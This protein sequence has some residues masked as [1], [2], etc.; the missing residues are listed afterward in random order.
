MYLQAVDLATPALAALDAQRYSEARVLLERAAAANPNDGRLHASLALAYFKLNL[1]QFA[2]NAARRAEALQQNSPPT[3]HALALFYAQ[4]GN[5]KRAAELESLYALSPLADPSAPARAAFLNAE[6][7]NFPQALRFARIALERTPTS[8]LFALAANAAEASNQLAEAIELHKQ[9]TEKWP[10][11]EDAHAALAMALLRQSR[12]NEATESL[13]KARQTFD[14]SPQIELALGVAHYAMR[15]FP[16]AGKSFF[17]VIELDP[18]VHQPYVFLSRM[19]DQLPAEAPKFLAAAEHWYESKAEHSFAPF[20]Y[21]KALLATDPAN[22]QIR[23]L[24]EESLRRDPKQW[25]FH[26]EFAQLLERQ[27][28]YPSAAKHF[29]QA[30]AADPNRPEPHYR[31]ARVYDRLNLPAKARAER[32]THQRLLNAAPAKSG[33]DIPK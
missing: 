21:A 23:P 28:D 4:S 29:E 19:L 17:R 16:E 13:Q 3:Q 10:Y 30:V 11:D 9:W 24:L 12:F 6:V 5:R 27:K 2:A 32:E 14:K 15:R 31:L 7:Q 22:T 33:M 18:Q 26:F 25:E 1:K 8:Q 20:V